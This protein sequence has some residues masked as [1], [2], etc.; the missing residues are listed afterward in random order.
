MCVRSDSITNHVNNLFM[1]HVSSEERRRLML[2]FT[3]SGRKQT[4]F[5]CRGFN[6]SQVDL[7]GWSCNT[8][9]LGI[10]FSAMTH[11][12]L[13]LSLL[14]S[15]CCLDV[16]AGVWSL[17]FGS[18]GASSV[19]RCISIPLCMDLHKGS[20]QLARL[21][22]GLWTQVLTDGVSVYVN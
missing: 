14:P 7:L 1:L 12:E 17:Q 19:C 10:T 18:L 2:F 8:K 5:H 22:L 20:S 15:V 4:S 11:T 21:I 9:D 6:T 16:R 3:L 13:L